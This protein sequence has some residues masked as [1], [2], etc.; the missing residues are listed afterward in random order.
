MPTIAVDAMQRLGKL[1]VAAFLAW[2]MRIVRG[3]THVAG[4]AL[5]AKLGGQ[6]LQPWQVARREMKAMTSGREPSR[7]SGADSATGAEK[8]N[9]LRHGPRTTR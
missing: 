8:K 7:E 9:C 3:L 2:I 4:R 6:S 1:A 5:G